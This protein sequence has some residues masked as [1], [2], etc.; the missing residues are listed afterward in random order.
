MTES[1]HLMTESN[2]LMAESNHL[3]AGSNL[4]MAESSLL[5]AGSN[6][7]MAE[8]DERAVLRLGNWFPRVTRSGEPSF[9]CADGL[10][11]GFLRSGT[12]R[13]A[14]FEVGNV[15]D[16]STIFVAEKHVDVIIAHQSSFNRS[17]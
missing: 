9:F 14:G 1:N 8:S 17:L 7:L 16:S 2:V 4:L 10:G 5:M 11:Q 3:M 12:E 15:R 13:G 6:V